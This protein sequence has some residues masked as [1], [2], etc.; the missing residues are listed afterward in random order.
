MRMQQQSQCGCRA[1]SRTTVHV[2]SEATNT[3]GREVHMLPKNRTR[4]SKCRAQTQSQLVSLQNENMTEI[5]RRSGITLGPSSPAG[6]LRATRPGLQGPRQQHQR[7][8]TTRLLGRVVHTRARTHEAAQTT[9]LLARAGTSSKRRH[10]QGSSRHASSA[11]RESASGRTRLNY[12]LSI[13]HG[14]SSSRR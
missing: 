7:T 6:Q 12:P 1:T 11:R 14:T 2:A 5:Y 13:A 4:E 9:M 8:Q 10:R 3:T